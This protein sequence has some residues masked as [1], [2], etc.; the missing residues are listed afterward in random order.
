MSVILRAFSLL[1]M[2]SFIFGTSLV[3]AETIT[4]IDDRGKAIEVPY[5]LERA[6]FLVENAMNTMYA[7]GGAGKITGRG[8]IWKEDIKAP[9]FRAIDPSYDQMKIVSSHNDQVDLESLSA[10]D[11]QVVFLWS[12]DWSDDNTKTIEETLGVP[13]YGVFIDSLDDMKKQPLTFAKMLGNE[14][15]GQKVVDIMNKYIDIVDQRTGT[16]PPADRPRVLWMWGDIYGT[17]GLQSTANDLIKMSGGVNVLENSDISDK[18][19]EHPV[20]NIE[21]ISELDP[22]VIYMWYNEKL[23]P[24]DIMSGEGDFAAWKDLTAVKNKRV[25]EVSDPFVFDF[26]SPRLPLALIAMAKNLYPDKYA[27]VD[28]NQTVDSYFSDLFHVHYPGYA[29]A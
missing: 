18:W 26:H 20:L 5:P 4:V 1:C 29:P 23:D 9:F 21:T 13:V 2:I 15:A 27:D 3:Y 22:D 17:A 7:V 10:A 24:S 28:L 11:P 19:M 25:Y 8:S 16:V 12:A 14:S 6:V